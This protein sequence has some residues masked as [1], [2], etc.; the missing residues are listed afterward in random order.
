M[1]TSLF[2]QTV[3]NVAS[4]AK[5][6]L[7]LSTNG[8]VE[9]AVRLVLAHDVH[10]LDNGTVEVG[11]ASEPLKVHVLS[12]AGCDCAD[13]PRAP[14]GWCKHRIAAGIAKRVGELLP[15]AAP[16]DPAVMPE[17]FP[18]NEWPPEEEPLAPAPAAPPAPV[19]PEAPASCNVY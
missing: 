3:A 2:R 10:F 13:Y 16:V 6:K 9:S 12:G 7:P 4:R 5:E 11:S 15:Q 1:T 17:P 19:L 8:R 18:D 14:E